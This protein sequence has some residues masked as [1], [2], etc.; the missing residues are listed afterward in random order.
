M[1]LSDVYCYDGGEEE[2]IMKNAASVEQ[3]DGMLTSS[4]IMGVP[5]EI[6]ARIKTVDLMENVIVIERN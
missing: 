5:L 2:L 6:K 1:C 3:K 4:N